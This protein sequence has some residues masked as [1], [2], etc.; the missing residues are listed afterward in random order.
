MNFRP[1]PVANSQ[2]TVS[3]YRPV[4][5]DSESRDTCMYGVP[6]DTS[7]VKA[8][9]CILFIRKGRG[10]RLFYLVDYVRV[11]NH[12]DIFFVIFKTCFQSPCISKF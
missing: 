8:K 4:S 1:V 5:L 10:Q 12:F 3:R 6:V 9:T 2:C 11:N 7:F